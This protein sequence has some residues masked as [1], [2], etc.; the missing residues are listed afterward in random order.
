MFLPGYEKQKTLRIWVDKPIMSVKF[1]DDGYN[2]EKF[3]LRSEPLLEQAG[4]P[5]LK[6]VTPERTIETYNDQ[7]KK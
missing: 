7:C 2:V 5:N 1:V 6:L 4:G 3:N